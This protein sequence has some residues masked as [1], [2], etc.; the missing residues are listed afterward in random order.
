L[1]VRRQIHVSSITRPYFFMINR[2]QALQRLTLGAMGVTGACRL[3]ES[4]EFPETNDGRITA[5]PGAGD[6]FPGA[7]THPLL[8]Q[9][10]RDGR[11]YVPSTLPR[12]VPAPLVLMLHG[13]SGSGQQ[14]VSV[15][16]SLSEEL[17]FLLLAPDSRDVT[18]DAIHGTYAFDVT[19]INDALSSTFDRCNVEPLRIGIAGFSDGATYALGL[20]RIN[21][22]LFQRIVAFSPGFLLPASDALKPPVYITHG[23]RDQVLPIELTSHVIVEELSAR[24]YDIT[25]REFDGGHWVPAAYAPEAFSWLISES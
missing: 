18:W 19:F 12:D 7:G 24:G 6:G 25:F 9:S 10:G 3:G 22:D 11:L 4:P 13:A 1:I 17:Q 23:V 21:G 15:F 8:L 2:R 16:E 5:R 20:G 14:T